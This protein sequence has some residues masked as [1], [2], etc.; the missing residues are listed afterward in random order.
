MT[1]EAAAFEAALVALGTVAFLWVQLVVT[2]WLLRRIRDAAFEFECIECE[3]DEPPAQP[4]QN[5]F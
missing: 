1:T 5:R 4:D 2:R 3:G